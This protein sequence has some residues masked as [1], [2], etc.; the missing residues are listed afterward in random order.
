MK[1]YYFLLVFFA[2]IMLISCQRE[3]TVSYVDQLKNDPLTTN[4]VS[5]ILK[6]VEIIN[7][8]V[9]FVQYKASK[10][11]N[12]KTDYLNQLRNSSKDGVTHNR[13]MRDASYYLIL[14]QKKYVFN[15]KISKLEFKKLMAAEVSK[16]KRIPQQPLKQAKR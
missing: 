3:N 8:N 4:Y 16:R 13:A 14:L 5:S 6:A 7:H 1:R 15:N 12:N 11:S 9:N 10:N 2:L